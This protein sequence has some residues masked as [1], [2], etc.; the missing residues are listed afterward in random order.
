MPLKNETMAP[1]RVAT[2]VDPFPEVEVQFVISVYHSLKYF[3][4]ATYSGGVVCLIHIHNE[5]RLVIAHI[6]YETIFTILGRY[7]YVLS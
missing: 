2:L 3:A 7:I 5:G 6:V 1:P 4:Y